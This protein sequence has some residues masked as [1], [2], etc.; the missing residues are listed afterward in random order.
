MSDIFISYKRE[1][2]E[3]AR[4]LADAFEAF[5]WEVWWDP[6]LRA[7]EHFDDVIEA[8][9]K[10]SKCVVV[11][12]SRAAVESRYV[13]DE[14]SQALKFDKLVPVRLDDAEPPF[15]FQGLHTISLEGWDGSASDPSVQE[16]AGD[17]AARIGEPALYRPPAGGP[18]GVAA[19]RS[20]RRRRIRRLVLVATAAGVACGAPLAAWWYY[21]SPPPALCEIQVEQLGTLERVAWLE[22]RPAAGAAH[23]AS[24]GRPLVPQRVPLS[25]SGRATLEVPD[26]RQPWRIAMGRAGGATSVVEDIRGCPSGSRLTSSDGEVRIAF[27]RR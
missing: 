16:L 2:Q 26:S 25:P 24:A 17:I 21:R 20:P 5:G 6:K 9:L 4:R 3:V 22:A 15:R 1:E 27:T 10:T 8:A 7:G 18:G 14:A 11:L 12:W 23:G 13:K 19:R